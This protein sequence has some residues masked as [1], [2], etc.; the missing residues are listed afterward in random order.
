[1]AETGRPKRAGRPAGPAGEAA[2][3]GRGG[4]ASLGGERPGSAFLLTSTITAAGLTLFS[5]PGMYGTA[6]WNSGRDPE[7]VLIAF[8]L[9]WATT[10]LAALA[11]GLPV[12]LGLRRL[13]LHRRPEAL[14]VAGLACGLLVSIAL[15]TA[16]LGRAARGD[17]FIV[18][19]GA[20]AGL[21]AGALWW[22]F[23][24]GL[25]RRHG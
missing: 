20:G 11:I 17:P 18:A 3:G 21:A 10:G 6:G 4:D 25:R 23:A 16:L 14:L 19:L 13:G 2:S 9:F 5:L 12:L 7:F 1:M 8:L 24:T 15:A 22:L